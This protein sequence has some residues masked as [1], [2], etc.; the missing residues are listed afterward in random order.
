MKK[1]VILGSLS[2]AALSALLL[3]NGNTKVQAASDNSQHNSADFRNSLFGAF[4]D[5]IGLYTAEA[6]KDRP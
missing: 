4:F 3:I 6:G 1:K 2:A 5:Y